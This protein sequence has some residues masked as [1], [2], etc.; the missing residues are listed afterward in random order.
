MLSSLL[1]TSVLASFA[2]PQEPSPSIQAPTVSGG[3]ITLTGLGRTIR[4]TRTLDP[5]TGR[6]VRRAVDTATGEVVDLDA[7]RREDVKALD[8]QNGKLGR[9]LAERI[10]QGGELQV[11]FWLNRPAAMPDLRQVLDRAI[12]DGLSSEDAR[13]QALQT[14]AT[15]IGPLTRAFEDT[16]RTKGLRSDYSDSYAPIVFVT[17]NAEDVPALAQSMSV[18]KVYYSSPVWYDE[19]GEEVEASIMF[20]EWASPSARTDAVH[21]RGQTGAGAK[22]LINDTRNIV[23]GNPF[24]PSLV[25]GSSINSASHATAVAGIVSAD[26]PTHTGA[27]PGLTELYNYG[28]SGDTVAPQAWAW[29]MQQGI[30]FGNCSWWNGQR[31]QINFLDRYF[32]YIIREFAVMMFKSCGNQGNNQPVTTPGNGY[33]VT[34]SGNATDSNSHDWDDDS[35]RSSSSTG[36]PIQGH[37]KPEVTSHGTGITSTTTSSPWIGSVGTGTSY[38]SPVVCGTAAL[39]AATDAQ[40]AAKPEVVKALLMAGAWN[41]IHGGAPLSDFDGAGAIDAAASQQA[42]LDGQFVSEELTS[43]SFTS[44]LRSYTID[45]LAGDETRIVALWFSLANSSYST[46]VLQ[47]DLD[48]V[49]RDPSGAVVASSASSFNPFE[50]VSFVPSTSGTYTVEMQ[51]QR[52][53]GSAEPFALA[54]T[55]WTDAATNEITINGTPNIGTSV[56][57]DWFDRYHPGEVFVGLLSVTPSPAVTALPNGKIFEFGF[58]GLTAASIDGSLPGFFGNLNGSGQASST[59]PIPPLLALIGVD[60]FAGMATMEQGGVAEVEETSK[61]ASFT[62]Q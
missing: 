46:D 4:E 57:I 56:T 34:S 27:A 24:L 3:E 41:N 28:G 32:D 13:R 44:G 5:N 15:F 61:V 23:S 11:V 19:E 2:A 16:L 54:W 49:V 14:A 37:E 22:V 18:E 47:M 50:I 9:D 43:G 62:I 26:H 60:V 7:L 53:D 33:N 6:F 20:D 8:T 45:L 58:D 40:L 55:S 30:S 29:G 51:N 31:G 21:R 12:D 48:M 10:A 59:L 42:V 1:L 17:M 38:A 52:F 35:M 36:N 39:L 25:T